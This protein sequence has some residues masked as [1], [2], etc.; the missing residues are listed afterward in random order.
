MGLRPG[1]PLCTEIENEYRTSAF[2]NVLNLSRITYRNELL[3]PNA[4]INL[5][6]YVI[7]ICD[8]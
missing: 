3:K 4:F 1:V 2:S 6:E 8:M 7:F 5:R